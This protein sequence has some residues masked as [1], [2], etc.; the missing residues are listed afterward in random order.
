MRMIARL[1]RVAA[2]APVVAGLLLASPARAT[3]TAP[4]P[5][6]HV[7]IVDMENHSFDNVLGKLCVVDSRCDGATTGALPDGTTIPLSQAVNTVP[8]VNHKTS[9]QR[10]AIDGGRMDGFG[11]IG[12]CTADVDH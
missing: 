10:K 11:N 7:V 6:Q 2:T 12:G 8:D 3:I 5:I 4:T 9:M 1:L